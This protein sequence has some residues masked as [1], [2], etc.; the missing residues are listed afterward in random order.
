MKYTVRLFNRGANLAPALTLVDAL[1]PGFKYIAGTARVTMPNTAIAPLADP[2]GGV[3]P[4]LVFSIPGSLPAESELQVTYRVRVG[5]GSAQGDGINRVYGATGSLR[6]D[7]AQARV[8]VTQG[9]FTDDACVLGKVFTD[10]NN[11]HV[12]DSEE[13]GIPGVRIYMEDGRYIVTDSEGKYSMCGV[14]PMT[15]VLKVDKITLPRGSRLTG[16]SN[17]NAGDAGSLFVDLK[18]GDLF[19]ADFALG[20]CSNPIMEQVRARRARGEVNQASPEPKGGPTLKYQGK[21]ANAPAR[22]TESANQPLVIER[23]TVKEALPVPATHVQDDP[24]AVSY[25][26]LTLPTTPYV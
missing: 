10:C 15:H 17:R 7:Q 18:N 19:R 25:T 3:G 9:V 16:T 1:P 26:H 11:N 24:V 14:S 22:S 21:P 5:V 13:I 23:E 2:S 8:L 6:S 12:Q 20:N 4:N